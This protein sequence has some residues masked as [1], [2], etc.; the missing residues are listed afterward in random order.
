MRALKVNRKVRRY[1]HGES[2]KK[3]AEN[4]QRNYSLIQIEIVGEK[5]R[6]PSKLIK[7]RRMQNQVTRSMD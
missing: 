1:T 6:P 2:E 3:Y 7:D 5:K 4:H